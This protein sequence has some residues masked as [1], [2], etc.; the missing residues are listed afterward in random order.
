[1]MNRL[2]DLMSAG[3]GGRFTFGFAAGLVGRAAL[4]AVASAATSAAPARARTN[5][6]TEPLLLLRFRAP[7][8]SAPAGASDAG[9]GACDPAVV[10]REC[11]RGGR[12]RQCGRRP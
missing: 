11:L 8:V 5:F 2:R 10:D 12:A 1:M 6:F 4:N 7:R 3:S 9:T